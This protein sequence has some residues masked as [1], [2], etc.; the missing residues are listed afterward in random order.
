MEKIKRITTGIVVLSC[1]FNLIGCT[2]ITSSST[3]N[4]RIE[5]LS[6]Y[7]PNEKDLEWILEARKNSKPDQ[8]LMELYWDLTLID[9]HNHDAENPNAIQKW[10]NYGIDRIVLFGNI[11]EPS[12]QRTDKQAWEHYRKAPS[13]VYPSFAGFPIYEPEGVSIVKEKLEQGYLNIGEIAAASTYSPVLSNVVWKAQHPNDGHL[14]EIYELAAKYRVPILLHIDPP[15]G[16]VIEHFEAALEQHPD[17]LFI[18]AHANAFNSP[19]NIEHLLANH[20]NVYMDFFAGFTAY[21]TE[22]AH[23]LKDFIPLM[24]QYPDRFFISTDSGFGLTA[25]QAA[26]ALYETIDLLSAETALKIAYQ[27]YEKIIELQPPTETQIAKINELSA[28]LDED[29]THL[30]NK[31]L[32]NELIF[33][34]ERKPK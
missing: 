16:I 25:E 2:F 1:F 22:S 6:K 27:N 11:S 21:N 3:E 10:Q 17:T 30:L 12:A 14:P 18:F 5:V 34:L 7:N 24:E 8:T 23:K 29:K 28:K 31:R 15:N 4:D 9:I 20:N 13:A 33:E 32:A 26:I 19:E